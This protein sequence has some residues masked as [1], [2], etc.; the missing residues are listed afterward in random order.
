MNSMKRDLRYVVVREGKWFI[1]QC[2]D[3]DVASQGRSEQEAVD[4]LQD[5][6]KLHY[7]PPAASLMPQ[8]RTIELEV[9]G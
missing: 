7:T 3:V 8:V 2:L 9:A 5:A 6:L 4:N 1:A